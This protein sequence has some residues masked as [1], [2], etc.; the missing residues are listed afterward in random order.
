MK[1][2]LMS[3]YGFVLALFLLAAGGT[4][5]SAAQELAQEALRVTPGDAIH[6]YIYESLFPSEKGKFVG[7]YHDKE[8]VVDGLGQITL[9]PLGRV[10]IAGLKPEEIAQVLQEKFRPF[11][12]DPLIIVVPMIRLELKGGFSQPG[13]Y[14]FNP[15][16]SFWEVMKEVGGLHS[17]SS[18]EDM[19]ISRKGEPIYRGFGEAFYRGQSLYELGLQSG[20]EI[21]APRVNRLSFDTIMRYLQFG[22]SMLIFYLTL[23]NYNKTTN[24]Y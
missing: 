19:Y 17:L 7:N 6:L 11:A 20:D 2:P 1:R 15:N 10:Q 9:G 23:M 5:M 16:I 8:F 4:T 3:G 22:M 12:K 24:T 14:R 13:L 18:F 21:V